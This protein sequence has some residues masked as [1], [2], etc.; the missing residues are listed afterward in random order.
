MLLERA[1]P[2]RVG[3]SVQAFSDIDRDPSGISEALR[4]I[5][6]GQTALMVVAADPSFTILLEKASHLQI[7]TLLIIDQIGDASDFAS[8]VRHCDGWLSMEAVDRELPARAAEILDRRRMG[9]TSLPAI[10]PRFLALVI[11]DLRTPLNVIGLTIRAIAQTVPQSLA[12]E[13]DEDL[14]FLTDNARQIERMLA[15]LGDYCRLIES[16]TRLS[17][18]EFDPRRFL[19]DFLEDRRGRVGSETVPIRLESVEGGPVEVSLDPDRVRLALQHALAN[20]VSSARESPIRI[21]SGGKDGRWVV[22]VII[23]RPP[24]ATVV[25]M[26]LRPDRFERLTG[27]RA[28]RRGLDLAIAARV[29]ELLGGSARLVIEQD[30]RSTILFDWPARFNES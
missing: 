20:A 11:H 6:S 19:A 17:T 1:F 22:E 5:Q 30:Q 23:E 15:Q 14:T 2:A 4:A 25:T 3:Q 29:S 10:D 16:E 9:M 27:T 28:E 26:E 21:R 12:P 8:R 7:P 18:M 24:P 13:I